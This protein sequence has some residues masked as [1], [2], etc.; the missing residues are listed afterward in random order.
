MSEVAPTPD[1]RA[2]MSGIVLFSS[3]LPPGPEVPSV[4]C[5]RGVMTQSGHLQAGGE[6]AFARPFEFR[7]TASGIGLPFPDQTLG[8]GDFGGGHLCGNFLAAPFREPAA[9]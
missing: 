8:L 9:V 5:G 6:L 1:L 3:G 7:F 2:R 4:I